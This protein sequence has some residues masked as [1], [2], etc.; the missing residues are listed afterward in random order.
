MA[1]GCAFQNCRRRLGSL[2]CIVCKSPSVCNWNVVYLGLLYFTRSTGTF[3]HHSV[4]IPVTH[5]VG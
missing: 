1:G 5:S 2:P 3:D 4:F